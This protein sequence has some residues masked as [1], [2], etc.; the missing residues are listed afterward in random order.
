MES[1]N[2]NNNIVKVMYFL[3]RYTLKPKVQKGYIQNNIKI[4]SLSIDRI[5]HGLCTGET[6]R[7][8][9]SNKLHLH[10]IYSYQEKSQPN[11]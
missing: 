5:A 4:A 11:T 10:K 8:G 1:S 2:N 3:K 7:Q 6:I 9:V